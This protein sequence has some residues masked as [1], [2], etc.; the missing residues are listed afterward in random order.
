MKK[1]KRILF[2]DDEPMMLICLQKALESRGYEVITTGDPDEYIR[3]LNQG[4]I[5]LTL[6]DVKMPKKSGF[7]LYMEFRKTHKVPVM[8]VTAY[9]KSFSAA[10]DDVVEMWRKNF[11]DGT[12]DIIYKPF[13]LDDLFNKVKAL[14]EKSIE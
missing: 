2:I 1:G 14:L 5:S 12:T 10:S 6:L 3:L 13:N 7:D 4:D 8:F 11:S 9:P